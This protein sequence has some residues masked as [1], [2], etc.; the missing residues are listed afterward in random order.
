MRTCKTLH[1]G[2]RRVLSF[3][4]LC[5]ATQMQAG[6]TLVLDDFESRDS[7]KKWQGE[8]QLSQHWSSHGSHSAMVRLQPGQSQISTTK[9]PQD[10]RNYDRLLF[11]IYC[12]AERFST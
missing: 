8:I 9:L 7:E 4:W 1:I 3:L 2:R 12:E 10:W 5:A 11:D 6:R